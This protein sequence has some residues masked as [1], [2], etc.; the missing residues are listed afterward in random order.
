[1]RAS[2]LAFLD[3]KTAYDL[4]DRPLLWKKRLKWGLP[5]DLVDIMKALFDDNMSL[6]AI[7]GAKSEE[8]PLESD[9]F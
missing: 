6:V 8:F 3:I 9:V 7:N 2:H 5:V 1:M 4:V